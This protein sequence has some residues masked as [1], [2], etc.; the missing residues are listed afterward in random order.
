MGK[1]AFKR[2]ILNLSWVAQG[3]FGDELLAVAL[4][5]FLQSQGV[6]EIT[7]YE[8]GGSDTYKIENDI[9]ISY[10]HTYGASRKI[11]QFFDVFLFW[12]Y[13]ILL[14]GGGSLFH[15]DMSIGW[16]HTAIKLFRKM[17]RFSPKIALVGVS[18][19]PFKDKKIKEKMGAL[20]CDVDVALFRDELSMNIA[21]EL[22][23]DTDLILSLDTAL[24][25]GSDL[26]VDTNN[27]SSVG[28]DTVKRIGLAL[29]DIQ[30]KDTSESQ[31]YEDACVTLVNGLTQKGYEVALFSLYEG[32]LVS[33]V[34]IH[35][36]ILRRTA[37]P[38][39]L[40][41]HKYSGDITSIIRELSQCQ[42]VVSM[43]LHGIIS[44]YLRQIPFIAISDNPK[45]KGF[46]TSIDYPDKLVLGS[47]AIY[48]NG[49]II[50]LVDTLVEG[51]VSFT[52]VVPVSDAQKVVH[53]NLKKM[54]RVVT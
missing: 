13:S 46:C 32:A 33:D 7:Y 12:R 34:D 41:E 44:A 24:Y 42:A 49:H 8:D 48:T 27:Q 36:R 38:E 23:S 5:K 1:S 28:N 39:L 43:R 3:N 22:T 29:M 45:H 37:T 4:R 53:E 9:E 16:K 30:T 18:L 54:W 15:S 35:A 47:D 17:G 2:K 20:L 14:I 10:L 6:P 31:K 50:S 21:K 51:E 25:L 52:K 40:V 11:K 19:G 26:S